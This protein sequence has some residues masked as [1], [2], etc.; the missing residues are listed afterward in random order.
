M[1]IIF[2]VLVIL[3]LSQS[4]GWKI[5]LFIPL[6]IY[7]GSVVVAQRA[8]TPYV[9]VRFLLLVPSVMVLAHRLKVALWSLP[10]DLVNR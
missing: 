8:L 4:V 10:L 3:G 7:E 2:A 9:K 1:R 6:I 5:T